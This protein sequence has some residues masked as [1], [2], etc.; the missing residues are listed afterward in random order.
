V[1][2]AEDSVRVTAGGSAVTLREGESL[3]VTGLKV[4]APGAT[5]EAAK[6]LLRRS[7]RALEISPLAR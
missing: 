1:V 5:L 3:V 6:A 7:G 2:G 4:L